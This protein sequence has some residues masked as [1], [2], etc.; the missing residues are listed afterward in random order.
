MRKLTL[1]PDYPVIE[2]KQGFV[3]GLDLD[4][5]LSFRGVPYAKAARFELPQTPDP[6]SGVRD[7][8]TYGDTCQVTELMKSTLFATHRWWSMSEDCLNLNIWTADPRGKAPVMVWFHGGGFF[9]GASIDEPIMD[10]ASLASTGRAVVVSVNHR[11]GC[12]GYLNLE[13]FG[14]P[15]SANA[16]L[17]DLI[18]ALQWVRENVAAFGGDPDNVTVFGQSGGGGRAHQRAGYCRSYCWNPPA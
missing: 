8:G 4:G 15:Q 18:A 14:F 2:T 10:G 9:S 1:T 11:L 6:W 13:E 16:G 12:L 3:R 17:Y 5:V 7:C